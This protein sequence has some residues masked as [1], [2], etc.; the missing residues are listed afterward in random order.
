MHPRFADIPGFGLL[1]SVILLLIV[2]PAAMIF[3]WK[4]GWYPHSVGLEVR[5]TKPVTLVADLQVERVT[6]AVHRA[7]SSTS[8]ANEPELRLNS[9]LVSWGDLRDALR[10]QLS[11]RAGRVVYIEGDDSLAFADIV[12]VIDIARTAWYGVPV[13]LLTPE[14]KRSLDAERGGTRRDR[15]P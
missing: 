10:A 13:V 4:W 3:G 8:G 15:S 9:R 14:L 2:I 5:I 11:R 1:Y 12:R 6:V 7:E